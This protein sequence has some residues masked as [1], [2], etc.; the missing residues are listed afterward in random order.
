MYCPSPC[1]VRCRRENH[2]LKPASPVAVPVI[3]FCGPPQRRIVP[4]ETRATIKGVRHYT[5]KRVK[6]GTMFTCV[7]CEHHV[8]TLD[9][10]KEAGNLRT[11]A[12]PAINRHAAAVHG[13]PMA[14]SAAHS[15]QRIRCHEPWLVSSWR[16][17]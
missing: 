9:F 13:Q 4:Q 6:D 3:T 2:G 17:A 8:T 1:L 12:A 5:T 14:A 7:R 11:Q 16:C 10:H 15:Q